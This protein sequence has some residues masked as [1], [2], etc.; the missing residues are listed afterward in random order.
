VGVAVV[1]RLMDTVRRIPRLIHVYWT[2]L[3]PARDRMAM[4]RVA[5]EDMVEMVGQEG[6]MVQERLMMKSLR[7]FCTVL[8]AEE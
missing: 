3:A 4:V 7:L 8:A 5:A 2:V 1:R 6:G